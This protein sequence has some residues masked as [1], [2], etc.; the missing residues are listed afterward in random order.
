M[1][2]KRLVA[3]WRQSLFVR[4]RHRNDLIQVNMIF[5][6]VSARAIYPTG[7]VKASIARN[8]LRP[9]SGLDDPSIR[10]RAPTKILVSTGLSDYDGTTSRRSHRPDDSA[11]DRFDYF[12]VARS[13]RRTSSDRPRPGA[14]RRRASRRDATPRCGAANVGIRGRA[15]SRDCARKLPDNGETGSGGTTRA[16][17]LVISAAGVGRL[18]TALGP[19]VGQEIAPRGEPLLD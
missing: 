16:R 7:R 4:T 9:K 8:C 10:G 14:D 18:K 3:P 2:A 15:G 6:N 1:L 12:I 11:S 5:I 17:A 19:P 13:R